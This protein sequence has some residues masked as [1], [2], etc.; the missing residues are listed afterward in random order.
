MS[1]AVRTVPSQLTAVRVTGTVQSA[2]AVSTLPL[3]TAA[4]AGSTLQVTS[5]RALA[6]VTLAHVRVKGSPACT[7]TAAGRVQ[8]S[9]SRL[10]SMTIDAVR[11][12]GVVA[13]TAAVP[14]FKV[15]ATPAAVTLTT[16]GASLVQVT[17]ELP[18]TV[19][20]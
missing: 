1:G 19:S 9:G 3:I 17:R 6:G 10:T 16:W 5:I 12:L 13:V 8:L 4:S 7:S 20:P 18:S 2:E 11:P 14:L 15:L